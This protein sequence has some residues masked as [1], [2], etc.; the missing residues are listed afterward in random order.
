MITSLS[1]TKSI[2]ITEKDNIIPLTAD[3]YDSPRNLS[4]SD[5]EKLRNWLNERLLVKDVEL[6]KK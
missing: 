4:S 3:I 5:Q 1:V 6:L 2:L